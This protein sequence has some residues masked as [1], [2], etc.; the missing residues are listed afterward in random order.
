MGT[1]RRGK[2]CTLGRSPSD[3]GDAN[4]VEVQYLPNEHMELVV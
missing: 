2:N 4:E 3:D 1:A